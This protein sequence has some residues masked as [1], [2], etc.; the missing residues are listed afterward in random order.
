MLGFRNGTGNDVM[1]DA[2]YGL[3]VLL[4]YR[5]PLFTVST[6]TSCVPEYNARQFVAESARA[7]FGIALPLLGAGV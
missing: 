5:C 6:F 4:N 7:Y 1:R 2:D 3:C